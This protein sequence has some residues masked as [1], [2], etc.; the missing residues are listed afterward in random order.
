MVKKKKKK[1]VKRPEVKTVIKQGRPPK[2]GNHCVVEAEKYLNECLKADTVP[3]VEE[4]ALRL[5]VWEGTI[6]RWGATKENGGHKKF[7]RVYKRLKAYQKLQLK[8][9][10]LK[11]IYISKVATLLLNTDHE[12][13]PTSRNELMGKAGQPIE[14]SSTLTPKQQKDIAAGIADAVRENLK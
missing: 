3:W 9:K 2:Y 1:T 14:V 7:R 6:S 8:K 5:G 11:G 13:I 12:V 10:S 4:L